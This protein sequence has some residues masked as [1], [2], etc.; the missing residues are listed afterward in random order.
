MTQFDKLSFTFFYD[1]ETTF[2][3]SGISIQPDTSCLSDEILLVLSS[4]VIKTLAQRH[5]LE[6]ALE[7]INDT[8]YGRIGKSGH[9]EMKLMS[10]TQMEEFYGELPDPDNDDED[11]DGDEGKKV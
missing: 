7:M 1:G 11:D 4:T 6:Q 8:G 10:K 2:I 3:P 5:G 9:F